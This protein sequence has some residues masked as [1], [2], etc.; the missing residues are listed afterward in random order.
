MPTMNQHHSSTPIA[1]AVGPGPDRVRQP[2][3]LEVR[4]DL[5]DFDPMRGAVE[6]Q[7]LAVPGLLEPERHEFV[8]RNP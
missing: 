4:E 1:V 8:Q 7:T 2:G 6:D 3:A 5:A